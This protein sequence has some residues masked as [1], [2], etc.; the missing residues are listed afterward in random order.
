MHTAR[1]KLANVLGYILRT[2]DLVVCSCPVYRQP[3]LFVSLPSP[4]LYA[5]TLPSD[6]HL[7]PCIIVQ[8]A[9]STRL[10]TDV[11]MYTYAHRQC[12]TDGIGVNLLCFLLM[13]SHVLHP[14]LV[15]WSACS[16]LR[17]TLVALNRGR[18]SRC[19]DVR[20][21][22]LAGWLEEARQPRT[23]IGRACKRAGALC[24]WGSYAM[25]ASMHP[26]ARSTVL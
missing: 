17:L 19:R 12:E 1:D 8:S 7:C 13:A 9:F 22:W 3:S 4:V 14:L 15:F 20:A 23:S 10:L 2:V 25:H 6:S 5:H 16:S 11:Y 26:L 24:Q 18:H 21:T